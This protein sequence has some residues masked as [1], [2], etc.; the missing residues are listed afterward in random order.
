MRGTESCGERPLEPQRRNPD[1]GKTTGGSP[2]LRHDR[3]NRTS[4]LL[5]KNIWWVIINTTIFRVLRGR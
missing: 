1:L 5:R 2:R 3:A 4:L